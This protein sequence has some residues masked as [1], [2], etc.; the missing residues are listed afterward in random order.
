MTLNIRNKIT[1]V[2]SSIGNPLVMSDLQDLYSETNFLNPDFHEHFRDRVGF[3]KKVLRG[4]DWKL[5]I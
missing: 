1:L 4:L 3:F 5:Y 2:N